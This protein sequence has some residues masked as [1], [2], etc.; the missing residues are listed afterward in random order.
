MT[1]TRILVVDDDVLA[2]RILTGI[3][4]A[5][6]YQVQCAQDGLAGWEILT[7]KAHHFD[8]VILDRVMPKMDGIQLLKQLKK[9]PD[10]THI[11]VILQTSLDSKED[12]LEGFQAGAYYYIPKPF[13]KDILVTVIRSAVQYSQIYRSLQVEHEKAMNAMTLLQSGHFRYRTL[14]EAWFLATLIS[15]ACP[16]PERVISGLSELLVNAIEHG[17]LGMGYET[18]SRMNEGNTWMAEITRRLELPEH[19]HKRAEALFERQPGEI[20]ITIRDE[21]EGFDWKRFTQ[22]DASRL[23]DD[24]G[25]GIALARMHS[26][27]DLHYI[28]KG[29]EV[30]ATVRLMD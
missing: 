17:N 24:H 19:Q 11:P 5:E 7:G 8:V 13:E 25:R 10:F 15:S 4:E 9:N 30:V 6:G 20:R 23:F 27:D 3:L 22:I 14:E 21:G 1:V 28:G 18:K 16:D 2:R 12:V 29:N 26:F